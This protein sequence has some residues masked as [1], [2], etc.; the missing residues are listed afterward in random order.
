VFILSLF[1]ME[2][3]MRL[4]NYIPEAVQ[5]AYESDYK[6]MRNLFGLL[7]V[8]A[9]EIKES[10][11]HPFPGIRVITKISSY[12]FNYVAKKELPQNFRRIVYK[13]C[14]RHNSPYLLLSIFEYFFGYRSFVLSQDNCMLEGFM[15]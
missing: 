8:T 15:W 12:E 9:E 3:G 11:Q 14:V 6:Y 5:Y 13:E 2:I 10:K 1:Q 4:L 7:P